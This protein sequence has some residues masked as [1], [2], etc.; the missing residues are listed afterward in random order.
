MVESSQEPNFDRKLSY[1]EETLISKFCKDEN[2]RKDW[3]QKLSLIKHQ[4]KS[5]WHAAYKKKDI[6][7]KNNNNW[8]D[9]MTSLQLPLT[10]MCYCD[11]LNTSNNVNKSRKFNKFYVLLWF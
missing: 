8:L 2:Q 7:E 3:K 11:P 1:V 9:G 4:F 6:F 10:G 5:R